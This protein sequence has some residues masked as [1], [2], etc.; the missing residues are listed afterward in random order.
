MDHLCCESMFRLTG[1]N[2]LYWGKNGDYWL[3]LCP[4]TSKYSKYM[5]YLTQAMCINF[6]FCS[7]K[8]S[9]L[10]HLFQYNHNTITQTIK[11]YTI[12]HSSAPLN[13]CD[14]ARRYFGKYLI[15][16]VPCSMDLHASSEKQFLLLFK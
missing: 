10:L 7:L 16:E 2:L 8:N 3:K 9:S 5:W 6:G 1:C 15:L 12:Q 11:H 4:V 14:P 13:F